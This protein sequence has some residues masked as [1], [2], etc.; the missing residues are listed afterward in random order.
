[1]LAGIRTTA[2]ADTQERIIRQVHD[3]IGLLE[4]NIAPLVTLL[5]RMKKRVGAKSPRWE[6]FE[7]DYAARWSSNSGAELAANAAVVTLTVP[8]STVFTVGDLFVVCKTVDSSLAPEMCRVGAIVDATTITIVRNVAGP[9]VIPV[10]SVIP[11]GCA[12]RIVGNAFE[13]GASLPSSKA[14][15]PVKHTTFTQIFRTTIEF[16]KTAIATDVYGAP[17]GDRAR[18]HAKK[19]KEHKILLN[20][21]LLFSKPSE[22][23]NG[24]PSGK[25][26]RTTMG[27]MNAIT[28][29]VTDATGTL[30]KKLFEGFSRQAF[31][32]GNSTKVLL[33]APTIKSALNEWARD[34][35]LIK[36]SETKYGVKIQQVETAHGTWLLVNDW[37]L[38]SQGSYG[39]GATALSLDLD[40]IRYLYLNN[41][42]VN[43][44]TAIHEDVLKNGDDKVVDEILTEGGYAIQQEK[45]H[46]RL[47]NVVDYQ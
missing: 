1:M 27:I 11:A 21:A 26:I 12:L 15:S 40:Q 36:P 34:F 37:M 38:E 41:N 16:S 32:Y 39:F 4:P 45:Y 33:C 23:M 7:D 14:T 42:G 19:L 18:E 35:L 46:A 20:S 17:S 24:G 13:E 3:E 8:D 47:F 25:P 5:M 30:T 2:Q 9:A 10:T 6:W 44:D 22:V 29:N 43:R 31:R 28:T